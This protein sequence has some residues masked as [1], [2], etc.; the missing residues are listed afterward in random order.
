[1]MPP[2]NFPKKNMGS[3]SVIK[4]LKED[5]EQH[6]FGTFGDSLRKANRMYTIH[7]RCPNHHEVFTEMTPPV[8]F[9]HNVD[10][11]SMTRNFEGEPRTTPI[12]H[13]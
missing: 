4:T 5:Q 6:R 12:Y 11:N 3:G 8:N 7:Y 10:S 2:V 13:T 1:M 9:A